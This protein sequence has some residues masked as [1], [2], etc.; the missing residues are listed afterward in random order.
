MCRTVGG[1]LGLTIDSLVRSEK[2]RSHFATIMTNHLLRV[3]K[4]TEV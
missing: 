3:T 1:L 2:A 4:K